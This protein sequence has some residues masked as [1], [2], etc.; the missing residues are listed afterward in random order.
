M[1]MVHTRL[2]CIRRDF[3]VASFYEF[4]LD[5]LVCGW[6]F[7]SLIR[8]LFFCGVDLA[9][10]VFLISVIVVVILAGNVMFGVVIRQ[11]LGEFVSFG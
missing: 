1:F 10:L 7:G 3:R 8:Y 2:G 6:G 9:G 11:S 4:A 5:E